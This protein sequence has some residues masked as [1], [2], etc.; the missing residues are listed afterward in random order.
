MITKMGDL[1][2]RYCHCHHHDDRLAVHQEVANHN[3]DSECLLS[4][5]NSVYFV[6][7]VSISLNRLV[8][9]RMILMPLLVMLLHSMDPFHIGVFQKLPAFLNYL[10]IKCF[11][12][13]PYM[14]GT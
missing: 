11:S 8:V 4:C 5:S 12:T 3:N 1:E 14:A 9:T 6:A 2:F 13:S 7:G 10:P